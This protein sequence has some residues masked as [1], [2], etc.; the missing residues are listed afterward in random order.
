MLN[1]RTNPDFLLGSLV[2]SQDNTPLINTYIQSAKRNG[3]QRRTK[4]NQVSP[5]CVHSMSGG[6]PKGTT[7]DKVT[8]SSK[9]FKSV[10]LAIIKL[11]LSEGIISQIVSQIVRKIGKK[12]VFS[13]CLKVFRGDLWGL[14]ALVLLKVTVYRSTVD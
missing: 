12:K 11:C 7:P 14:L 1:V 6:L 3:T 10:S 2:G 8:S 4:I 9:R 13:D 5:L